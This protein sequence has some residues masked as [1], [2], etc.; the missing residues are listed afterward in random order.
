[1]DPLKMALVSMA[2][3]PL[4]LGSIHLAETLRW[5]E[6]RRGL[7]KAAL[8]ADGTFIAACVLLTLRRLEHF[9]FSVF[10]EI[11]LQMMLAAYFLVAL[12]YLLHCVVW[13]TTRL[14]RRV[15][16]DELFSRV[17]V[18]ALFAAADACAYLALAIFYAVP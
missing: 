11:V 15:F 5:Y 8:A 16:L 13:T 6:P 4:G 9:S 17:L 10:F 14:G 7:W 3:L 2:I 18:F 1:M 12:A